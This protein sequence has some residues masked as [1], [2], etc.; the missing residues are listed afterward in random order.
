M[1]VAPGKEVMTPEMFKR[2]VEMPP[3]DCVTVLLYGPAKSGKTFVMGSAGD[4]SLFISNGNGHATL[5]SPLF[6]EK[7]GAN[8]MIVVVADPVDPETGLP[9]TSI[10]LTKIKDAI[11]YALINMNDQFDTICIDDSTALSKSAFWKGLEINERT[12]KSKTM[13]A[14]EKEGVIMSTVQDY[15]LEMNLI[16]G[17]V[18]A[19]IDTCQRYKKH[20][21]I[22]AHE[23]FTFKKGD[24]IGELPTLVKVRPAFTGQTFPDAVA[25]LFDC[26]F[27]TE[28]VGG[29]SNTA[30]R[31]R[32]SGDEILLAGNRYGAT[33]ET[34]EQNLKITDMIRRIK[35]G[36]RA[37]GK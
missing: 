3:G 18:T 30:Y 16:M 1:P 37:K 20:L 34:V 28:A 27:H 31:V 24:Q 21:I 22:G 11:N 2:L 6:K 32:T 23:R 25:S 36:Q 26:V 5:L 33:F 12:L 9:E 29:G 7:V 10:M 4:R 19:L 17:F 8:P 13:K 14:V 35:D 15:G